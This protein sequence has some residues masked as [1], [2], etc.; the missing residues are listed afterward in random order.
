VKIQYMGWVISKIHLTIY[1]R[2]RRGGSNKKGIGFAEGRVLTYK[3]NSEVGGLGA[4]PSPPE[5]I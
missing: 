1:N 4:Q 5:A 2:Y 3:C